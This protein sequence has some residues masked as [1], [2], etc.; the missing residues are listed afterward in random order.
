MLSKTG[1][2]MWGHTV[3]LA[4]WRPAIASE[5]HHT[6]SF[7]LCSSHLRFFLGLFLG[8]CGQGEGQSSSAVKT[9]WLS[10]MLNRKVW[11]SSADA[12]LSLFLRK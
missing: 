9:I 3:T 11:Q 10:L 5:T 2:L 1:P 8:F 6:S 12:S 4:H 7:P